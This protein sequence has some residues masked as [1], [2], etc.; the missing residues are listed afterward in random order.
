V[1][2]IEQGWEEASDEQVQ[3]PEGWS[4]KHPI[5]VEIANSQVQEV[6]PEATAWSNLAIPQVPVVAGTGASQPA[7]LCP[8]AYHRYKAKF[9]WFIPSTVT[10]PVTVYLS[11]NKDVLMGGSTANVYQFTVT[12][13]IAN[14]FPLVPD[15]DGQQPLYAMASQPGTTVSVMDEIFKRVQ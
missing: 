12:T 8:H 9:L 15:Y 10:L 7:Q 11:K 14:S 1:V 5:Q 13:A 6:A 2:S 3:E 4:Q